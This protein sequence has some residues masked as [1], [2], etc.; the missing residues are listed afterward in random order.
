M[1]VFHVNFLFYK[2]ENN[3]PFFVSYCQVHME[4]THTQ[5]KALC[6]LT[7]GDSVDEVVAKTGIGKRTLERWKAEP[8]FK[9]CFREAMAAMYDGAVAELVLGA[10]DAA[11]TLKEIINNEE[12]PSK[13]KISAINILLSNAARAKDGILEARLERL[14]TERSNDLAFRQRETERMNSEKI[15]WMGGTKILLDDLKTIAD[16]ARG[17]LE[18]YLTEEQLTEFTNVMSVSMQQIE[19]ERNEYKV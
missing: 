15:K 8:E 4:L 3:P 11:K 7:S 14:E 6:L 12:T 16:T 2:I 18:K 1:R 13:N 17:I 9:K 10:K 5:I 19:N